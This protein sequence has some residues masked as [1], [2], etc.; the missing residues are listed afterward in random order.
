MTE[1]IGI[2]DAGGCLGIA[3]G[4]LIASYRHELVPWRPS[5]SAVPCLDPAE[6]DALRPR[7]PTLLE[8]LREVETSFD[9]LAGTR[10][11]RSYPPDYLDAEREGWR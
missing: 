10:D 2:V 11:E 7:L 3:P 8:E 1:P 5:G 6:L 9:D 4:Q